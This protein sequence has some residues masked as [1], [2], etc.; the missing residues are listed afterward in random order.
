[1]AVWAELNTVNPVGVTLVGKDAPFP[2]HVPQLDGLV[3]RS[4][5]Q[6][7]AVRVKVG[8]SQ[9]RFVASQGFE[10]LGRL[11]AAAQGLFVPTGTI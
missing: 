7:V 3:G 6:E 8:A 2:P 5:G 9:P 10:K 4:G 11:Q 1:M